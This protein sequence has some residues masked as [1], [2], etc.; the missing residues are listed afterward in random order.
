MSLLQQIHDALGEDLTDMAV[1]PVSSKE[2]LVGRVA[3][4]VDAMDSR[5]L[6]AYILEQRLADPEQFWE[7]TTLLA[8]SLTTKNLKENPRW[9]TTVRRCIAH[10]AR[11]G[12]SKEMVLALLEQIEG[13][14]DDALFISLLPC[15][16]DALLRLPVKRGRS[17]ELALDT[18]A[19]HISA[20]PAPANWDLEGDEIKLLEMDETVRPFLNVVPAF[21]DFVQPFLESSGGGEGGEDEGRRWERRVLKKHLLRLLQHPLAFLDLRFSAKEAKP[22]TNSRELAE[23]VVA[24]LCAVEKSF[25]RLLVQDVAEGRAVLIDRNKADKEKTAAATEDVEDVD[26]AEENAENERRSEGREV[27]GERER[28]A[29]L[30]EFSELSAA[31]LLYLVQVEW[32]GLACWPAVLNS[33][34]KLHAN[35]PSVKFLLTHPAHTAVYKGISLLSASLDAVA[36][37]SLTLNSLDDAS[38]TPVVSSLITVMRFCPVRELRVSALNVFRTLFRKTHC[39]ARHQ[40]MKSVLSSCTHAGVK[41]VVVGMIKDDVAA[42]LLKVEEDSGSGNRDD[43]DRAE[44]CSE[45]DALPAYFLGDG[46]RQLLSLATKLPDGAASDLLEESDLAMATLNLLRFLTLRDPHS[47]NRSGFWDMVK[48][49][50][51]EYLSPLRTGLDM[52]VGH[53]QLELDNMFKPASQRKAESDIE[54]TVSVAGLSLPPMSRDQRIG[55]MRSALTTFDMMK[56][57]LARLAELMDQKA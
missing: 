32:L 14:K 12:K 47:A 43:A 13:F 56:C 15:L 29:M 37:R 33:V 38:F 39:P 51:K 23:S 19:C 45:K 49:L 10:F 24:G 1:P 11:N 54:S 40:L 26:M 20:L 18:L 5:S 36:D 48:W 28:D 8:P 46:L 42:A 27:G 9:F 2:E 34:Y 3:E 21:V 50:E 44:L 52:S 25:Y 7:L 30:D 35:L 16:Q 57:V 4:S 31:C 53:Y 6:Q 55:I 17:L 22:K 41:A